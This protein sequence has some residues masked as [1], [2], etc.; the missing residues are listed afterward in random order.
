MCLVRAL[1]WAR[2]AF[3]IIA[4]LIGAIV[5]SLVVKAIFPGS[6]ALTKLN[7]NHDLSSGQGVL[8]ELFLTYQFVLSIMMM[9]GEKHAATHIAPI[10][11]GLSLFVAELSGV[12][13]TGGSLNPA[14]SFG[15]AL[16]AGDFTGSHW[17][18]WLGPMAGALLAAGTFRFMKVLEYEKANPGQ[19]GSHP[20]K[21]GQVRI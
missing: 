11:I 9:A 16:A 8:I 1:P 2:G 4:Q 13:F 10:G 7:P 12:Y 20:H 21:S 6:L 17:I 14:R 15:P 3:L 18:Y 19:D 5:S